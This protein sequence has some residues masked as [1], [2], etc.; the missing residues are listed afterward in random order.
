LC[1]FATVATKNSAEFTESDSPLMFLGRA[2]DDRRPVFIDAGC[3][4]QMAPFSKDKQLTADPRSCWFDPCLWFICWHRGETVRV[5][6]R[7]FLT[8][9]NLSPLPWNYSG[10]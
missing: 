10:L 5:F 8:W 7:E 6:P 4:A 2:I 9:T 3:N 1:E